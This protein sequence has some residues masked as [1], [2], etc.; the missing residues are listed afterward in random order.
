MNV[1][2]SDPKPSNATSLKYAYV[3]QPVPTYCACAASNGHINQRRIRSNGPFIKFLKAFCIATLIWV[4]FGKQFTSLVRHRLHWY[5]DTEVG[6]PDPRDGHVVKCINGADWTSEGDIYKEAVSP[7]FSARRPSYDDDP[8]HTAKTSFK[9]PVN[10]DVLYLLSRGS[11]AS[12]DVHV[13]ALDHSGDDVIVDIVVSYWNDEALERA[14]VCQL[15]RPESECGVGIFTPKGNKWH[16][17][18]W[19]H[20]D[21]L[22]FN[23]TVLF[24]TSGKDSAR[25]INDFGTAMVLFSQRV[26]DLMDLVH[27]RKITLLTINSP[28]SATSLHAEMAHL[29][30]INAPISGSFNISS[31]ED[32]TLIGNVRPQN[33]EDV[34]IEA[35]SEPGPPMPVS[36]LRLNTINAG[37]DA[38]VALYNDVNREPSGFLIRN[39]NG[40][41]TGDVKLYSHQKS[42]GEF[43]IDAKSVNQAVNVNVSTQ[44]LESSLKLKASTIS[45]PVTVALAPAYEGDL[46]LSTF[47]GDVTV[48]QDGTVVDPS[49][50]ERKRNVYLDVKSKSKVLG[51]V[52]WDEERKEGSFVDISSF[53]APVA[54]HL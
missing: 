53:N 15:E 34:D 31:V 32:E 9:L 43:I 50:K 26:D 3:S 14:N 24:P 16:K 21:Y 52:S 48:E 11:L 36:S 37:I 25:I 30:T 45:A 13:T 4:L 40:P 49:G 19:D 41:I 54:V 27:F 46:S 23:V 33:H 47:W 18:R 12:G 38:D 39:T 5:L 35:G 51:Y 6:R 44:P 7:K 20:D 10:S 2:G 17:K 29:S 8:P 1:P 22:K 42:G 28:I